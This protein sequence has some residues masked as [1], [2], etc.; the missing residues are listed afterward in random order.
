[1]RFYEISRLLQKLVLDLLAHDDEGLSNTIKVLQ[2]L[3][4]SAFVS[5]MQ[6]TTHLVK[7]LRAAPTPPRPGM[8]VVRSVRLVVEQEPPAEVPVDAREQLWGV[9]R[10]FGGLDGERELNIALREIWAW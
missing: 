5:C 2:L 10:T 1:M 8:E 6:P 7:H 4:S 3:L 9:N